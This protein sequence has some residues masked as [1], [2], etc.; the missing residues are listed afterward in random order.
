MNRLEC[1][2][3]A[4]FYG[5]WL[6]RSKSGVYSVKIIYYFFH[7]KKWKQKKAR[8][9]KDYED[10]RNGIYFMFFYDFFRKLWVAFS[11]PYILGLWGFLRHITE[12]TWIP[13]IG[14]VIGVFISDRFLEKCVFSHNRYI[15]Y[16]EVFEHKDK[17][18]HRK[19]II[20]SIIFEISA[21]LMIF[22]GLFVLI[23]I[24]HIL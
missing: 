2:I 5:S 3:N 12:S 10:Y 24:D 8:M 22:I 21:Y 6:R 18:W 19:W 4:L 14:I 23:C 17:T 7:S 9:V 13:Y 11:T 1:F 20:I 16:F 15:K